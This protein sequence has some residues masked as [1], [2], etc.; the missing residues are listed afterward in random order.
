MRDV[1]NCVKNMRRF[2]F[3]NLFIIDLKLFNNFIQFPS[4]LWH[5]FTLVDSSRVRWSA[6]TS[7][8]GRR[9][10][11]YTER[12]AA[13]RRSEFI[14]IAAASEIDEAFTDVRNV[15]E[16][17]KLYARR[18]RTF[19]ANI[20]IGFTNLCAVTTTPDRSYETCKDESCNEQLHF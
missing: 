19:P 16:V 8:I 9:I 17:V 2:Q 15:V 18:C 10:S 3:E 11:A 6:K 14:F 1:Q 13:E 7:C 5:F 4:D 20:Q 12:L